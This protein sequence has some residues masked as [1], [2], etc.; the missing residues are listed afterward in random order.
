MLEQTGQ[1]HAL[2]PSV[3]VAVAP[4]DAVARVTSVIRQFCRPRRAWLRAP[5]Q[6]L[7]VAMFPLFAAGEGQWHAFP[8]VSSAVAS[9]EILPTGT[10]LTRQFQQN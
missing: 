2:A 9:C 6:S 4:V 10:S 1:R 3:S 5:I 7:N 8:C